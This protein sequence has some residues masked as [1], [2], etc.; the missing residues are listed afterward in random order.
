M[1]R[2]VEVGLFC[3]L[4]FFPSL[5]T[6]QSSRF[7]LMA[8]TI[9]PIDSGIVDRLENEFEKETAIR[10]RHVGAGTGAALDIAKRGN[11]DLVLVHAKSLEEKFV[12]EGFGTERID[13]MYND[14]VIVGPPSDPA[15][16]KGMEQA[17]EALKRISERSVTFISRGDRSGTHVAEMELWGKAGIKPS[18][19]W[20]VIYEKGAEGNVPTLRFTNEKG[21]YTVMDRATF[22]SLKDQI[23]LVVLVEKDEVLLN[24]ISLIP[25][26]PKKFAKVNYED[27][28]TFVKW[29]TAVDKGQKII[30][31]F[32]KEKYGDPLFFPNSKEWRNSQGQKK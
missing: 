24:Y 19:S 21:A 22:L 32:G 18:G 12:N 1:K 28:M 8:S 6:A 27:A 9:G 29:L 2:W 31:D 14:F 25:V 10:V 23:K 7:I 15:G 5:V 17:T 20:Y 13:L 26:N 16:I 3:L 11:V 4:W 30:R